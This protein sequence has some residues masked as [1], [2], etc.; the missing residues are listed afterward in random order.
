MR[1]GECASL[2][3]GSAHYHPF[4]VGIELCRWIGD[5]VPVPPSPSRNIISL[6]WEWGGETV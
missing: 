5:R 6:M 2:D 4:D 3:L 1:G